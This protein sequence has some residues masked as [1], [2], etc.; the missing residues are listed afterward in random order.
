M[1][2]KFIIFV[3]LLFW[4]TGFMAYAGSET[5]LFEKAKVLLFDRQW[6]QALEVLER[7]MEQFPRSRRLPLALL[8]KAR[9]LEEK[10]AYPRALESYRKFLN[11]SDND[12]LKEEAMI[13]II[14]IHHSLFQAGNRSH[15]DDILRYLRHKRPTVRYYAAFKLSYIRDIKIASRGVPV[16]KKIISFEDDAELKDRAKIALMRI[17][18]KYLK[19][20]VG[21]ESPQA[22]LLHIEAFN[23]KI[24]K[25]TFSLVIPFMFA[26]LALESIPENDKS[27]LEKRGYD[28]DSL[29]KK[30]KDR[31]EL[32]T[33]DDGDTVIKVWIE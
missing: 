12:H 16:L 30:L 19:E 26:R 20:I 25:T 27:A 3:M 18:P 32:L 4:L 6:T 7:F 5:E 28:I 21:S 2:K 31:G 24:D 33:I 1:K 29:L 8:Y 10:K 22:K 17:D 9:C 14:D 23:K 11:I 15:I 13:A